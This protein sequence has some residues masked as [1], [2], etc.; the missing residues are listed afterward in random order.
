M[1]DGLQGGE[2]EETHT[3]AQ[4]AYNITSALVARS[5]LQ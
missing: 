5:G 2:R 3:V 1:N 4:E